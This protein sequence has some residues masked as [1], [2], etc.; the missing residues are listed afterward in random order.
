MSI[1][2]QKHVSHRI[3]F[4]V[5]K[6]YLCINLSVFKNTVVHDG[7]CIKKIKFILKRILAMRIQKQQD[8]MFSIC[9]K[10]APSVLLLY[11]LVH[12]FFI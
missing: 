12:V 4:A 11:D 7:V 1:T 5:H 10:I 8:F 6:I 9:G 3:F 2:V